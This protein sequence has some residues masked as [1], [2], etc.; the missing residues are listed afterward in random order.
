MCTER[1]LEAVEARRQASLS[2]GLP[3]QVRVSSTL[4]FHIASDNVLNPFEIPDSVLTK[5]LSTKKQESDL[6]KSWLKDFDS[7]AKHA[8]KA[9][10]QVA[11]ELS[12]IAL[13]K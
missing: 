9:G 8:V 12:F 13:G 6:L 5:L 1:T 2:R 11:D 3:H 4:F 10:Q 7:Y